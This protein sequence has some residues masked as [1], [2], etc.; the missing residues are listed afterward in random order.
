[1][2]NFCWKL[3]TLEFLFNWIFNLN[4]KTI[5]ISSKYFL[6]WF[7]KIRNSL[8]IY[9]FFYNRLMSF[10]Q[11]TRLSYQIQILN[12]FTK[13]CY[14]FF[15]WMCQNIR[16]IKKH[17]YKIPKIELKVITRK[18]H[19]KCQ[20]PLSFATI[21]WRKWEKDQKFFFFF[22]YHTFGYIET[23]KFA[24]GVEFIYHLSNRR[25]IFSASGT[26]IAY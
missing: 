15:C 17:T 8:L 26:Q 1:M 2:P 24:R 3:I 4:F 23:R 16:K 10:L 22:V 7:F 25:F 6:F 19:A 5:T 18:F 20:N 14:W 9:G 13:F 11:T 12:Y 21:S